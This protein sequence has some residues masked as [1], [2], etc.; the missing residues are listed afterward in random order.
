VADIAGIGSFIV[1]HPLP[2]QKRLSRGMPWELPIAIML[3]ELAMRADPDSLIVDIGA[4]IG[5]LTVPLARAFPGQV[6]AFEPVE[7]TYAALLKNLEL[8]NIANVLTLKMACSARPGHGEMI[9]VN[10]NNTGMAKLD[11]GQSGKTDVTTLDIEAVRLGARVSLIK[12]DVE[13]HEGSVLDGAGDVLRNHRP[14]IVCELWHEN[15]DPI[16]EKIK[17]FGYDATQLFRSD[18]VLYPTELGAV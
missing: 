13:G 14:L 5:T 12:M 16:F 1:G 11:V 4:N 18:Y 17:P 8:N 10:E 6:I 15:R 3:M 2:L 9:D 7:S